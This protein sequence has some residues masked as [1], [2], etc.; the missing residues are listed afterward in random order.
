V[1]LPPGDHHRDDLHDVMADDQPDG[2]GNDHP[3]VAVTFRLEGLLERAVRA[4]AERDVA[5][6]LAAAA[7]AAELAEARAEARYLR[8]ALDRERDYREKYE[9]ALEAA[10]RP[11]FDRII[12][13]MRRRAAPS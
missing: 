5:R 11:W 7:T 10:T 13:A 12:A 2:H 3:D 4:E 1:L 9:R 8:E 6:T